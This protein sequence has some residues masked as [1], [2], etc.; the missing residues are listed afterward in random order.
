M[1]YAGKSFS[2]EQKYQEKKERNKIK[3]EKFYNWKWKSKFYWKY[4]EISSDCLKACMPHMKS[5][6]FCKER[7]CVCV[8]VLLKG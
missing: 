4:N 5:I 7:E 1:D 6:I 8:G 3:P 2:H